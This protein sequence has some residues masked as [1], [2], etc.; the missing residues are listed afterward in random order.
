M[1]E[2][3]APYAKQRHWHG[4]QN[5]M[6]CS[7]VALL[8]YQKTSLIATAIFLKRSPLRSSSHWMTCSLVV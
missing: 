1:A 8:I 3:I 6:T 5:W 2:S 7:C 4:T